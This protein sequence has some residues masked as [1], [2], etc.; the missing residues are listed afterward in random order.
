MHVG[1]Q[2]GA[3]TAANANMYGFKKMI[4]LKIFAD[5]TTTQII[6]PRFPLPNAKAASDLLKKLMTGEARLENDESPI[7]Y[8][9]EEY[10]TLESSYWC[11][12]GRGGQPD[13][14]FKWAPHHTTL[15]WGDGSAMYNTPPRSHEF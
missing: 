9:A 10:S 5:Y 15:A 7:N 12:R 13:Q 6:M 4:T 3:Q 1:G 11:K 14:Y 8:R 2:P